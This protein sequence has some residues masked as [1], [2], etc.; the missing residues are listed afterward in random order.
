VDG[1]MDMQRLLEAAQQMQQQLV[2]AQQALADSEVMGTA[3]GGLVMARVNGQGELLGLTISPDAID[4]AD[5]VET[6][7]TVADLV[8]AAIRAA[9]DAAQQ[10]QA[11]RMGPFAAAFGDAVPPGFDTGAL[12]LGTPGVDPASEIGQSE[13]DELCTREL[14]SNSSTS[15]PDC[16]ASGRRARSGSRFTSSR[17]MPRT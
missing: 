14:S 6:A 1:Q 7:E 3:G 9:G 2:N 13:D 4:T 5:A 10:L 11:E 8:V 17:L 16:P 12:G 15:S